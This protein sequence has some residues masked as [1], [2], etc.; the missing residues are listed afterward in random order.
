MNSTEVLAL[1][2][3]RLR[4]LVHGYG[5]GVSIGSHTYG[6]VS[7]ITVED[8]TFT[9]TECGIRIKSDRGRGGTVQRPHLPQPQMT[10]VGIPS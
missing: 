7:D 3:F 5:H 10:N 8:C 9:N 4:V 6:G 1:F 2:I